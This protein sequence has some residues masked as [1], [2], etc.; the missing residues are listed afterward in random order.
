MAS[1][2]PSFGGLP[3]HT[4]MTPS[5]SS[6]AGGRTADLGETV[7]CIADRMR[8]VG[9]GIGGLPVSCIVEG[10]HLIHDPYGD[11]ERVVEALLAGVVRCRGDVLPETGR[12]QTDIP[13][14]YLE[15]VSVLSEEGSGEGGRCRLMVVT[16]SASASLLAQLVRS[17]L[18]ETSLPERI[19]ALRGGLHI[20]GAG[21]RMTM[22]L[23]FPLVRNR[24]SL[25][26]PV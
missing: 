2:G 16:E 7:R 3:L 1:L 19:D 17:F 20:S 12:W 25:T 11:A 9:R 21:R 26:A 23:E 24:P 4:V 18:I 6:G 22:G 14:L 5:P 8:R 10:C 13:P 15:V